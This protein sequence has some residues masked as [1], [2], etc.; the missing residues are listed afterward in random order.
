MNAKVD[1]LFFT[2]RKGVHMQAK[3]IRQAKT[4]ERNT[5]YHRYE[6]P[7]W[8]FKRTHYPEDNVVKVFSG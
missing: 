3:T 2:E 8:L 7:A 6:Q 4:Y 5:K 1:R